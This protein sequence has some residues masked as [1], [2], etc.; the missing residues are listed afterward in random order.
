MNT[1]FQEHKLYILGCQSEYEESTG[2]LYTYDLNTDSWQL[3]TN[4]GPDFTEN[5]NGYEWSNIIEVEDAIIFKTCETH[6]Y[7]YAV[8]TR[9]DIVIP[10][11]DQNDFI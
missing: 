8:I 10:P 4:S 6:D 2:T 7:K 1:S 9:N 5:L 3:I 11:E